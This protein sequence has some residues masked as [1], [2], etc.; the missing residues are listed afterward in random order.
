[1][2]DQTGRPLKVSTPFGTN[3]VVCENFSGEEHISG[4]FR[5]DLELLSTESNLDPKKIV[6]Q[7]V[8]IEIETADGDWRPFNGIC[9]SFQYKG[10]DDRAHYYHAEIVPTLWL[11]SKRANCKVHESTKS[12]SAKEIIQAVLDEHGVQSKWRLSGDPPMRDY[13]LQY[14]ETDLAFVERLAQEEGIFYYFEHATGSHT[15]ILSNDNTQCPTCPE[16]EVELKENMSGSD[17]T[18]HLGSWQRSHELTS[19]KYEH[20]DYDFTDPNGKNGL[21]K[22]PATIIKGYANESLVLYD[23]PASSVDPQVIENRAKARLEAEEAGHEVLFSSSDRRTF[24]AG[25]KFKVTKHYNDSQAGAEFILTH[26]QHRASSGGYLASG[27]NAGNVYANTL[28]AIPADRNPRPQFTRRKP[29]VFGTQLAIVT[30]PAGEEIYT[31]E[32]GRIKILFPWDQLSPDDENSSCWVRCMTPWA[33]TNWG[34]IAIPRIDQEVVVSFLN[35]DVDHPVVIG[36]LYNG[37]SMPPYTLPDNKTQSGV[38]THSTKGGSPDNFNEIRFEDLKDKEQIYIHAERDF[39][40]VI[41]NNESRMVGFDKTAAGD[42]TVQ[43]YN[44][45]NLTVG[46]GSGAGKQAVEIESDRIVTI[47]SGNDNLTVKKGKRVVTVAEGNLETTV[48]KGDVATSA[49]MGS[50]KL[51]AMKSIELKVGSSSIQIEPTKITIKAPTVIV[52]GEGKLDLLG[53]QTNMKGDATTTIKGGMVN[54]N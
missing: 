25:A 39:E 43:I 33:G 53:V 2:F 52:K 36:M 9:K 24:T 27:G 18:D 40:C 31:D 30:G 14:N 6:G 38:K 48:S 45:Q 16:G 41:E 17:S 42:Q 10:G 11:L 47:N 46:V 12:K 3:N 13:C 15:L 50:I 28:R 37:V 8:D 35:G 26:V 1:M 49:K 32:H 19:G 4:L 29:Q 44:N 54:I 21:L 34:M 7:S 22:E 20:A 51:E 23:Y 5:F